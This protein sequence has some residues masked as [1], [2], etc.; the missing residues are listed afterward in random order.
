MK[1]TLHEAIEKVLRDFGHPMMLKEIAS[2]IN[3]NNYYERNDK[4]PLESSQIYARV[5]KY[6]SLFESING[7]VIPASH[8]HWRQIIHAYLKLKETLR[9]IFST[10]DI[11]FIIATLFFYKRLVDC[12]RYSLPKNVRESLNTKLLFDDF[13]WIESLKS[14]ERLD[15]AP[16]KT[17][18]ELSDLLLK[19]NP[20]DR[21]RIKS[22]IKEV[23]TAPF[24]DSEYGNIYEYLLYQDTKEYSGYEYSTPEIIRMVLPELVE[25]KNNESVYDPVAGVGGLL[26]KVYDSHNTLSLYGTEI[27]ARIAQLGNMNLIMHGSEPIIKAENCFAELETG[28]K[29]DYILGD[30][31]INGVTNTNSA[32][33]HRLYNQFDIEAPRSG[34]G[35]S[36]LVLFSFSKLSGRGKAI[37]T[38]SDSFLTKGGKEKEIRKLL[39]KGDVVEAVISL[40]KGTYRPYTEAKPS[41]LVLNRNKPSYLRN[42]IKFIRASIIE[43]NKKSVILDIEGIFTEYKKEYPDAKSTQIIDLDD[44]K[45]DYNLSADV[46]DAQ[47]YLGNEML[48]DNTGKYLKDIAEISTGAQPTKEELSETGLPIVKIE[49]LSKDIMNMYLDISTITSRTNEKDKYQRSV[50][51]KESVLI[52]KIGDSLKPTIYKPTPENPA[53]LL[54]SGIFALIPKDGQLDLEY[55]YYQLNT[56]FIENQISSKK[57][58]ALIPFFNKKEV[59]EIVIPYDEDINIQK[60]FVS[61]QKANLIAEE[62]RKLREKKK[63][64]GYEV[65]SQE[66][67]INI[68]RTI[69]HQLKHNLSGIDAYIKKIERIISRHHA[70]TLKEYADDDPILIPEEGFEVPEN[71]SLKEIVDI[72]VKKSTLLNRIL[73]DVSEAI[74]L[75]LKCSN[76]N[77]YT[78]LDQLRNEYQDINIEIRG[79]KD[80]NLYIS[81]S[82]IQNMFETII[83]NA[84]QHS[85]LSKDKLKITFTI[86]QGINVVKIEYRNNGK[87]LDISEKEY[88]SI[89]TKSRESTGRGIGGYYINKVIE[90]HGGNLEIKDGLSTGVHMTIEL[91]IKNGNDE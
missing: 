77:L 78:I 65:V 86:K 22:L 69:T 68:V 84:K 8:T 40:P 39:I 56:A 14:I 73:T 62:D 25:A 82:H 46:Y 23:D 48:K 87:P 30:L 21:E 47:Y 66:A 60:R 71:Y 90:A 13:D 18:K 2:M 34:K 51:T 29:Y 44:L 6:P 17:F 59:E 28:K 43:E 31:P 63:I 5:K 24:N 55:L 37:I 35:F 85:G 16:Q 33:H 11:Q 27:N 15:I 3:V 9:G 50:I 80:L 83:D 57:K 61:S 49:N 4:R 19:V 38:V 10:D 53:I 58:R 7:L 79:D 75:K 41:I 54:H 81:E 1:M 12:E 76:K 26:S 42:R 91:P 52:A 67:E 45:D 36:S 20:S 88:K 64:L 74:H 70:N 32:E 72:V 89:V